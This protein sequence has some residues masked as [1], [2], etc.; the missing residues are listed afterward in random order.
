MGIAGA[1]RAPEKLQRSHSLP[2]PVLHLLEAPA[3]EH[4]RAWLTLQGREFVF[5][6]GANGC[7]LPKK[8]RKKGSKHKR[9]F[10]LPASQAAK[11]ASLPGLCL[12]SAGT[13]TPH[14]KING[15]PNLK[16]CKCRSRKNNPDSAAVLLFVYLLHSFLW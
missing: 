7:A 15:E 13:R 9:L 11:L 1:R 8:T 5:L 14:P 4:I 3:C 16:K 10:L 2:N 12:G 6:P